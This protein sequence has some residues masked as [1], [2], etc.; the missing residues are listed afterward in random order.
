MAELLYRDA[1][2]INRRCPL[3][4]SFLI[5]EM[6]TGFKN[7]FG[8]QKNVG[9]LNRPGRQVVQDQQTIQLI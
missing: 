2:A 3:E 9:P 5:D 6:P 4:P 1:A 8:R 7:G